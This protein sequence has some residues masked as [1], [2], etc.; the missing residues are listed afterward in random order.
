MKALLAAAL[1]LVVAGIALTLAQSPAAAGETVYNERCASCHDAPD[2]MRAPSR[3]SLG[4]RPVRA[5]LAALSPGGVMAPQGS[6]LS[7]GEKQAVASF[8]SASPATSGESRGL[9]RASVDASGES[10]GRCASP[11]PAL[12]EAPAL[13]WNGW[14]NDLSNA[15]FQPA[16]RAD[17]DAGSVPKLTL[18]WAYGF[19]GATTASSQPAVFGG[20]VFVG[21]DP[22]GMHALD[23][24]SGCLYWKYDAEAGVRSA[25]VVARVAENPAR[26]AVVF[27]DL[28]AFVYALDAQTGAVIWKVRADEHVS[29]RITGGPAV[30]GSRVFVPVSSFEEGPAARPNYPCCTFRGSVVALDAATGKTM[31]QTFMIAE[32]PQM[33]GKNAAGT[34]LWKPAGVGVW[35]TPTIDLA[36]NT[37]YVGTGNSYT[38]PAAPMSDSI[39]ALDIDTGAIRWFNQITANDAFVVGC[40][41]GNENCPEQVGPDHDFGSSPILRTIGGRRILLA[42]QKS[43]VMFA[44]DPDARGKVLWQQRVGK[45]S[46][47]GGIEWGPAADAANVYIAVSDV[48]AQGAGRSEMPGGLHA[49]RIADGQR[50][51]H[52][53]APALTCKGGPG[54]SGAQSAAISVIPGVA[55][56]GSVDGHMRAYSTKDGKIIWEFNTMRD[57][58]T[59]N[60]VKAAGGSI[61]AGG[62]VIVN[63]MLLTNSGY[64]RWRGK[65]GNVLLAF[66]LP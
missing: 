27:G 55:F 16:D 60:G 54:C 2:V 36:R 50:L 44:L 59:V 34:P 32:K 64:G 19:A 35:S 40:K 33:V 52:T 37:I 31:W 3:E 5:I 8:L 53:P 43:G 22:G 58:Q 13:T 20:R 28:N 42:G 1:T 25:A 21:S 63:G 66:G 51:W 47:L 26:Y 12:S 14:G 9:P 7:D 18:K 29:A 49:L 11:A 23:L 38:A 15:R 45:G 56:S 46:E 10:R 24:D 62:P 48:I 17:L 61:D 4:A 65:P 39:V 30:S 57:F 41:A 6:Q